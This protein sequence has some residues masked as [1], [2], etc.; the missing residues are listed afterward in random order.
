MKIGIVDPEIIWLKLQ[1][2]TEGK[3]F[4]P[5]SKFGE[6]AKKQLINTLKICSMLGEF[7]CTTKDVILLNLSVSTIS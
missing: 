2:I 1:K 6:Q 7:M 5:V 3:I 4:S